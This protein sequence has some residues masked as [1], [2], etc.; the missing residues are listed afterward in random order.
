MRCCMGSDVKKSSSSQGSQGIGIVSST[1]TSPKSKVS[2]NS[3][4]LKYLYR[5]LLCFNLCIQLVNLLVYFQKKKEVIPISPD[6]FIRELNQKKNQH[7][8]SSPTIDSTTNEV[9]RKPRRCQKA[10]S[11]KATCNKN[12]KRKTKKSKIK[13]K[14]EPDLEEAALEEVCQVLQQAGTW[15]PGSQFSCNLLIF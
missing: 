4:V 9:Q 15:T 5:A 12:T 2:R 13:S 7:K 3:Y 1:V 6:K 10:R 11:L 8:I 14:I